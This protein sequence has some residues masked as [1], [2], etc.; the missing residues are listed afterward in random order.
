MDLSKE[1]CEFC[2]L[3]F[4]NE[5][6]KCTCNF[7]EEEKQFLRNNKPQERHDVFEGFNHANINIEYK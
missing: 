3:F 1:I 2:V 5:E 7:S 6:L 4:V